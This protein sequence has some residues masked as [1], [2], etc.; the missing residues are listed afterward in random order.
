MQ[1]S[2]NYPRN[3][4]GNIPATGFSELR[5]D[6]ASR[7]GS[8]RE[9][10][11]YVTTTYQSTRDW[12]GN[13]KAAKRDFS[14]FLRVLALLGVGCSGLVPIVSELKVTPK[15]SPLWSTVLLALSGFI[16][17]FDRLY[18]FTK[19]WIRYMRTMQ[20]MERVMSQFCFDWETLKLTPPTPNASTPE[21]PSLPYLKLANEAIKKL[22]DLVTAETNEWATEFSSAV[23]DLD[24][25]TKGKGGGGSQPS[26]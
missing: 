19:G 13:R 1:D 11:N 10:H 26:S 5:W 21:A 16:V 7:E 9:L 24:T 18:G 15:I 22:Q 6:A 8:Q 20:Q 2:T 17:M 3:S 12:Y 14:L 23:Q 25:A 4:M